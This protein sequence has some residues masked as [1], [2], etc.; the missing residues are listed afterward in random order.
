MGKDIKQ[1][2]IKARFEDGILTLMVPKLEAKP[3]V[4]ENHFITIEG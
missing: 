4:E 3:Q 1:T 2:D